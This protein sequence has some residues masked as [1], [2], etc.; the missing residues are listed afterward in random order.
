MSWANPIRTKSKLFI[1]DLLLA[2]LVTFVP[3]ALRMLVPA[4][5]ANLASAPA[6]LAFGNA[7]N[8]AL[9]VAFSGRAR[10]LSFDLVFVW[11]LSPS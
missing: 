4:V 11:K 8:A 9:R 1:G 5:E 6:H 10:T 2:S 7:Q 3:S